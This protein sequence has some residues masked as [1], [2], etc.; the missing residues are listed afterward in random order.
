MLIE[1]ANRSSSPAGLVSQP[2]RLNTE[3][4]LPESFCNLILRRVW[5][6][7]ILC[8]YIYTCTPILHFIQTPFACHERQR[9]RNKRGIITLTQTGAKVIIRGVN[10]LQQA[11]TKHIVDKR[12]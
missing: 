8:T 5:D 3:L 12:H 10:T 1:K 9:F 11:G 7:G 6:L 4:Q 2:L